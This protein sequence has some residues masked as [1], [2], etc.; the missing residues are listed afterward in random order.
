MVNIDYDACLVSTDYVALILAARCIRTNVCVDSCGLEP[1]ENLFRE[2][3][4]VLGHVRVVNC[5]LY[6]DV[7]R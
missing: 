2:V 5:S 1:L 7:E 6:C 4:C 3:L